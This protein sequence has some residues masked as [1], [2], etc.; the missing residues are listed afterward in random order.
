MIIPKKDSW[1]ISVLVWIINHARIFTLIVSILLVLTIALGLH[2]RKATCPCPE[3]NTIAS[4][5][6]RQRLPNL[7]PPI[8]KLMDTKASIDSI[9]RIEDGRVKIPVLT[10]SPEHP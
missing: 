7:I 9:L 4:T 10:T 3:F 6:P 8:E 5:D 1:W 2:N